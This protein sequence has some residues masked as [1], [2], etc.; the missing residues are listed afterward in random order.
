MFDSPCNTKVEVQHT[1][2]TSKWVEV[3]IFVSSKH[4]NILLGD[5]THFLGESKMLY[6]CRDKSIVSQFC[7]TL[8]D[9]LIL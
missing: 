9:V 8:I 2:K 4:V 1:P 5:G 6:A 3:T 7:E